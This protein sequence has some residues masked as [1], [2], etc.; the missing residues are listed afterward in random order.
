LTP[1]YKPAHGSFWDSWYL[2]G[3]S[4]ANADGTTKK[5]TRDVEARNTDFFMI[6]EKG[7]I[8]GIQARFNA[9][10]AAFCQPLWHGGNDSVRKARKLITRKNRTC[11]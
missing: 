2:T 8:A 3:R 1:I 6:G 10:A 9:D 11:N 7:T 4:A 5:P